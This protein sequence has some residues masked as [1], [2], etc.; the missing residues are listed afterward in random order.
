MVQEDRQWRFV[1]WQ[2]CLGDLL[3]WCR[4]LQHVGSE[5]VVGG[6]GSFGISKA[7]AHT[8]AADST[9][10]RCAEMPR[11]SNSSSSTTWL[12]AFLS[13]TQQ[14]QQQMAAAEPVTSTHTEQQQCLWSL[15]FHTGLLALLS[16]V[17]CCTMCRPVS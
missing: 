15:L 10:S 8:G 2:H 17:L 12:L 13:N 3:C 9:S 1:Y 5:R 11:S 7:E 14:Q 16:A 4:Q 6:H